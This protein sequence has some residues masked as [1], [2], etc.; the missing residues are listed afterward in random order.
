MGA[1]RYDTSR[2]PLVVVTLSKLAMSE[3]EFS[4]YLDWMDQLFVRG[5]KFVV[6]IDSRQAPNLPAQRR[7]VIGERNKA[8]IQRHPDKL[9]A[10]AFVISSAMQRGIFT[11]ILWITR[12]ADTTR[13]FTSVSEGE[14]WLMSRLRS[15]G[16]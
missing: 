15:A 12:S 2:W 14:A 3:A 6:L 1:P 10:F 11:A 9:L 16:L 4:S 5:G 7:Q 13:A 8:I